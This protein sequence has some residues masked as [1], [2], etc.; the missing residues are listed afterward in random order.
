MKKFDII[1]DSPKAFIFEK[2]SN[3]TKL[4][5]ILAI[6]YFIILVFV[7]ISYIYDFYKFEL[8]EYSMFY[9]DIKYSDRENLKKE[10]DLN[11]ETNFL[12]EVFAKNGSDMTNKFLIID[13]SG[14][15]SEIK[16]VYK[17]NINKLP[18]VAIFYE[19]SDENCTFTKNETS[20]KYRFFLTYNSKI[21]VHDDENS[22]I[23]DGNF[24]IDF[25]FKIEDCYILESNWQFY[26]YQNKKSSISRMIDLI[27][28]NTNNFTFGKL[29]KSIY[30]SYDLSDSKHSIQYNNKYYKPII[31]ITFH[32]DLQGIYLYT[33]KRRSELDYIADVIALSAGLF[34]AIC[35]IFGFLYSKSFDAYKIVEKILSKENIR[36]KSIELINNMNSNN[37]KSNEDLNN[38]NLDNKYNNINNRN[39]RLYSDDSNIDNSNLIIND[40]DEDNDDIYDRITELPKFHFFDFLFNN[41][42]NKKCCKTFKRQK[43]ISNSEE[44]LYKYFSVDN[45]VYNQIIFENLMK[46][47]IWNNPKMKSIYN[48]ELIK[49]LTN[50]IDFYLKE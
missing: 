49:G 23:S 38:I 41:L 43:L 5:G 13:Y 24:T 3:K 42:Y 11:I 22:P 21:M 1:S 36:L 37:N 30:Y 10:K 48:N 32:N 20:V 31:G 29:E 28:N 40:F 2:S 26:N 35:K 27:F 8:Y 17:K 47:Y 33:R 7:I 4:G 45:I 14:E 50:D 34:N 44:I 12:F 16:G 6:I 39:N 19:C 9:K 25:G 15:G 46:D 18:Y